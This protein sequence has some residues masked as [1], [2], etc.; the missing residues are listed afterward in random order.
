MIDAAGKTFVL[1]IAGLLVALLIGI[2]LGII[3][4]LYQDTWVDTLCMVIALFAVSMP[5]F[6]F[7]QI[8]IFGFA[9]RFGWLPAISGTQPT[10][11]ILPAF[12]IGAIAAGLISRLTR[13]TLSEVLNED[14]VRT[15]RAKG[16]RER[17]V[18]L[19]HAFKNAIVPVITIVGLQFGAMLSGAVIVETVF[20][21]PGLGSLVVNAILWKDYPLVQ[22]TVFFIA[23]SYVLVNLLVDMFYAWM[24]PRI[25]YS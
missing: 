7:G 1:S 8:L 6:W 9:I 21:R 14:Y 23:V 2:P 11:L 18:V 15:A 22:G 12:T 5:L 25:H 20:S 24:D 10:G 13:S 19:G 16:L 17:R 4:A 3:A